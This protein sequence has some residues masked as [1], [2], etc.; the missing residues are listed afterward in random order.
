MSPLPSRCRR[1]CWAAQGKNFDTSPTNGNDKHCISHSLRLILWS[2]DTRSAILADS[3][4]ARNLPE[5]YFSLR[6][7][8]LLR[9]LKRLELSA[10][11]S[12]PTYILAVEPKP[13]KSLVS[14]GMAF[15]YC[16]GMQGQRMV[17]V[18][19]SAFLPLYVM[20]L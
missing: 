16:S 17:H 1:S 5:S 11:I 9:L 15:G 6:N 4:R 13:G 18:G 7:M 8:A 14:G 2:A 19:L 12:Q 3:Q 10:K 20:L